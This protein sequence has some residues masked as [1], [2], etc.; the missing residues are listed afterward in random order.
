MKTLRKYLLSAF[1]AIALSL[2][3]ANATAMAW[4]PEEDHTEQYACFLSGEDG[5]TCFYEC[6][7]YVSEEE[8]EAALTR[9]GY[10][11]LEE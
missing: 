9:G 1:A 10:V 6:Y 3:L 2:T 7:C 8:C 4:C 11:I 5:Y